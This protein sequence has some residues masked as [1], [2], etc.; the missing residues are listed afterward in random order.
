[1]V[2]IAR[3]NTRLFRESQQCKPQKHCEYKNIGCRMSLKLNFLHPHLDFFEDNLGAIS[4]EHGERFHKETAIME[5]SYQ[6]HWDAAMM[7]DYIWFLVREDNSDHKKKNAI[8]K[9]L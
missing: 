1:M 9:A 6:D 4:K 2:L 8:F 3:G 7:R 5:K